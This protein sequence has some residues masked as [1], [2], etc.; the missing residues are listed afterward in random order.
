MSG[1][2]IDHI[3]GLA[4]QMRFTPAAVR[5]RQIDAAERFLLSIEPG[6]TYSLPDVV[7]AI[8]T[9]YRPEGN[10]NNELLTGAALQHDLGRLIEQVSE[11][12]NM[13]SA[14][15]AEPVL[16]IEDVTQ[17]FN[18]TSKTIQRWR[19]RGLAARRFLFA[20]G[21]MR[22]GFLL[23]SVERFVSSH[24]E[25]VERGAN[26]SQMTDEER[27]SILRRARRLAMDCKCCIREI[28]RR[29]ARKLRR[30]PLTVLHTI[31]KHDA[32]APERAIFPLA[33]PEMK[34]EVRQRVVRGARKGLGLKVLAKKVNDT[35]AN[36]YRAVIEERVAK[37]TA[38]KIKFIDDPIY[39]MQDAE[40]FLEQMVAAETLT[41]EA[42]GTGGMSLTQKP[43]RDL[44]A[45]LA[46]LYRVPLLTPARER[47]L[48]LKFHYHKYKFVM[49]RRKLE[50]EMAKAK[51]LDELEGHLK[52]VTAVKNQI[53]SANLRLV[54][55]IARRHVR[56]GVTLM[57]LVSEGNITLMRA[58]ES[59]DVHKGNRFS[60]YATLALMKGF[61]RS[62]PQM[63][64]R[65]RISGATVRLEAGAM[66]EGVSDAA[67]ETSRQQIADRDMVGKLLEKLTEKERVAVSAKFGLEGPVGGGRVGGVKEEA[68]REI[69]TATLKKLEKSAMEKLRGLVGMMKA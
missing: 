57:E 39:H 66:L 56:A 21:K 25:T 23:S 8:T 36:V 9:Q 22:V 43:P 12:L 49:A 5:L 50:P 68:G 11:T 3:E 7:K 48:F 24:S 46:E 4:S 18:V 16:L 58:I 41:D 34:P 55:S 30:S 26:F 38:R 61:A 32:E 31:K 28:S 27:E 69:S 10:G 1:Y 29:I 14:E 65:V 59:F 52:K 19:R 63:L 37:L 17:R 2:Q 54:V 60:T 13:K 35:R 62:V 67:S 51:E 47:A 45:Y 20:D 64:G 42:G 44:P 6:K 53:L 15:V 33:A 40:A